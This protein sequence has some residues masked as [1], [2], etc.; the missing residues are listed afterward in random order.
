MPGKNSWNLWPP[1]SCPA[2]PW[3]RPNPSGH[4]RPSA[5]PPGLRRWGVASA[6]Q[7]NLLG[8]DQPSLRDD[9]KPLAAAKSAARLIARRLAQLHTPGIFVEQWGQAPSS[10]VLF[11]T[12]PY[13]E[14]I[15]VSHSG[16]N[17][18]S[19]L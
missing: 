14:M 10:S 3:G 8:K 11:A 5:V 4:V 6:S 19:N 16:Q 13:R 1:T 2:V 18:F 9:N 12:N 7:E 15:I 17:V